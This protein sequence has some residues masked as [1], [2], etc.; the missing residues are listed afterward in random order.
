M[1]E[2]IRLSKQS[3]ANLKDRHLPG[4]QVSWWSR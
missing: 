3:L 4:G 2:Y 1:V